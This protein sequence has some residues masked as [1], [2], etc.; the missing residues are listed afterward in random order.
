MIGHLGVRQALV[1][2]QRHGLALLTR[3]H[4]QAVAQRARL[5]GLLYLLCGA[6]IVGREVMQQVAVIAIVSAVHRGADGLRLGL[7][8][9]PAV[10]GGAAPAAAAAGVGAADPNGGIKGRRKSKKDK[11]REAAAAAALRASRLPPRSRG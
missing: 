5:G 9:A 4:A 6:G 10:D 3:Q 7:A 11:L 2:G 8:P 1:K